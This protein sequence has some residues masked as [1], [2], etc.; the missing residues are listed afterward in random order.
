MNTSDQILKV[1]LYDVY[2]RRYQ[3]SMTRYQKLQSNFKYIS[4]C[5]DPDIVNVVL[6]TKDS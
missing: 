5:D 3:E 4:N 2:F 6:A 1:G